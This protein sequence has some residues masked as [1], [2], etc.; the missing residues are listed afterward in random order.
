MAWSVQIEDFR[1][2]LGKLDEEGPPLPAPVLDTRVWARRYLSVA[3]FLL[4]MPYTW[5]WDT[6]PV[7]HGT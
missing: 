7:S 2:C 4:C 1:G 3:L 5:P 6:G